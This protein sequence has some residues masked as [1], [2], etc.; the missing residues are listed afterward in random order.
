MGC[1]WELTNELQSI[2]STLRGPW[3]AAQ[4][5]T[6]TRGLEMIR[7]ELSTIFESTREIL[8]SRAESTIVGGTSR[9][10]FELAN[11]QAVRL[12]HIIHLT[13]QAAGIPTKQI[14][15]R[16]VGKASI[17]RFSLDSRHD[18]RVRVIQAALTNP[19]I[20]DAQMK[21]ILGTFDTYL[22]FEKNGMDLQY[23]FKRRFER[24]L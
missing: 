14:L 2:L 12:N 10:L 13:A 9:R 5:V 24:N 15:A 17:G 7:C 22:N 23:F 18:E 3:E 6:L 20:I 8:V 19:T 16:Y 4:G 11:A 1:M 21:D